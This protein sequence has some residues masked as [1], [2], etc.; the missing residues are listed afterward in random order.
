MPQHHANGIVVTG[1][2]KAFIGRAITASIAQFQFLTWQS[3][4]M[5]MSDNNWVDLYALLG[6][7]CDAAEQAVQEK[8]CAY[9][10]RGKSNLHKKFVAQYR[11]ILLD[12]DCRER[13]NQV[14]ARHQAGDPTALEF[15][16][17]LSVVRNDD[18]RRHLPLPPA[19]RPAPHRPP[20]AGSGLKRQ[21][22]SLATL[23]PVFSPPFFITADLRRQF[24]A[25]FEAAPPTTSSSLISPAPALSRTSV[26]LLTGIVATL[27][28]T[29]IQSGAQVLPGL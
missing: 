26:N 2:A 17:F 10:A 28:I 21:Q 16:T 5:R 20:F 29:F 19:H 15:Q 8:L 6:V 14:H 18:L 13:Y 25:A 9:E 23:Q 22:T 7:E 3:I 24:A 11:R 12:P 1:V 4:S 27:L